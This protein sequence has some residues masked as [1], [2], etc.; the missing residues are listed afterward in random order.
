MS[1]LSLL[2]SKPVKASSM[3]GSN[4]ANLQGQSLGVI[5]E[6]VIDTQTF[7]VA[8]VVVSFGG[9][10]PMSGKLFAMPFALFKYSADK[11][12]YLLDLA[13]EKLELAPGFDPERW[14]SLADEKWHRDVFE[15]YGYRPWW[16]DSPVY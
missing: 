1:P 7:K 9:F 2:Q 16:E 10:F 14:P 4:V 3:I 13:K 8:Y 11:G 5:K 12:E 15:Y 6:I